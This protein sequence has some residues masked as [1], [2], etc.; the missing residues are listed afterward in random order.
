MSYPRPDPAGVWVLKWVFIPI[1]V[2]GLMVWLVHFEIMKY[3]GRELCAERGFIEST[4]VPPNR[5]GSGE[6]YILRKK[7]NPDG[8]VDDK[9]ILFVNLD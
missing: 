5:Y 3:K 2:I 4:Y 1:M 7:R 6:M 8:T 9:A